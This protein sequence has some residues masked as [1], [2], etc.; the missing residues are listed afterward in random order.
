MK[1]TA[2]FMHKKY[3]KHI[4]EQ[5][6]LS[7]MPYIVRSSTVDAEDIRRTTRT[8][9]HARIR[10]RSRRVG[11]RPLHLLSRLGTRCGFPSRMRYLELRGL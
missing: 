4:S 5:A 7:F 2:G 10:S 6:N 9:R 8:G 1:D 3:S 11:P